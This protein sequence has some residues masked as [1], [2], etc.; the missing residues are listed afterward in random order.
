MGS[1]SA[2]EP[3][4]PPHVDISG[5][6]DA[7]R[8]EAEDMTG[9][10]GGER[11]GMEGA[12]AVPVPVATDEELEAAVDAAISDAQAVSESLE[13]V[14]DEVMRDTEDDEKAGD[15]EA[16][17]AFCAHEKVGNS[18]R[19]KEE[20]G[21]GEE[22]E[23]DTEDTIVDVDNEDN[24]TIPPNAGQKKEKQKNIKKN[25]TIDDARESTIDLHDECND[26]SPSGEFLPTT[27]TSGGTDVNSIPPKSRVVTMY[28]SSVQRAAF[29]ERVLQKRHLSSVSEELQSRKDHMAELKEQVTQATEFVSGLE[30]ELKAL[31]AEE[32]EIMSKPVIAKDKLS[33]LATARDKVT[34]NLEHQRHVVTSC[35]QELQEARLALRF[36]EVDAAEAD[37]RMKAILKLDALDVAKQQQLAQTLRHR[38]QAAVKRVEISLQESQAAVKKVEQQAIENERQI[39]RNARE[40]RKTALARLTEHQRSIARSIAEIQLGRVQ[41]KAK[42]VEALMKLKDSINEARET[43]VEQNKS[44]EEKDQ[45][46]KAAQKKE[47]AEL[48]AQGQNPYEV[49]RRRSVNAR[50]VR[51]AAM[52]DIKL[53]NQSVELQKKLEREEKIYQSEKAARAIEKAYEERFEREMGLDAAEER[54]RLYI[55]SITKDGRDMLDPT[56]RMPVQPREVTQ[57]KTWKFGMSMEPPDKEL[58]S[59]IEQTHSRNKKRDEAYLTKFSA[60]DGAGGPLTLD[61]RTR[62]TTAPVEI[63]LEMNMN[64][65]GEDGPEDDEVAVLL[66]GNHRLG[67]RAAFEAP[68]KTM[69]DFNEEARRRAHDKIL[70]RVPGAEGGGDAG[71]IV[72]KPPKVVFK[73]VQVGKRYRT[74]VNVTNISYKLNTFKLLELPPEL[75]D[76]FTVEYSVDKSLSAGMACAL[77]VTFEPKK[78]QDI[79][80]SISFLAY[81]GY[82]SLPVEC[83]QRR[84]DIAFSTDNVDFGDVPVSESR[85]YKLVITNSGALP[86]KFTATTCAMERM[87][88]DDDAGNGAGAHGDDHDDVFCV[89]K[90]GKVKGNAKTTLDIVFSPSAEVDYAQEVKVDIEAVGKRTIRLRGRG[91]KPAVVVRDPVIDFQYCVF[92]GTYRH[93]V[94]LSNRGKVALKMKVVPRLEVDKYLDVSPNSAFI[95]GG[96][97]FTFNVQFSPTAE[98]LSHGAR[99]LESGGDEKTRAGDEGFLNVPIKVN[100]PGQSPVTFNVRAYLTTGA[101]EIEP[102]TLSF[103]SVNVG[104]K[105]G[106]KVSL[107]NRSDL[108]QSFGFTCAKSEV[109]MD[110]FGLLLPHETITRTVTYTA[111]LPSGKS[112]SAAAG[113]ATSLADGGGLVTPAYG[114]GTGSG[115][116]GLHEFE[117]VCRS[118]FGHTYAIPCS[119]THVVTPLVL[120]SSLVR[121]PSTAT[122]DTRYASV[123]VRNV[124]GT[125]QTFEFRAPPN[126]GI[127]IN[128]SVDTV[129]TG[130]HVRVEVEYTPLRMSKNGKDALRNVF[131]DSADE[132]DGEEEEE[133]ASAAVEGG[134][135]SSGSSPSNGVAMARQDEGADAS[136]PSPVGSGTG[137]ARG[138]DIEDGFDAKHPGTTKWIAPCYIK[139]PNDTILHLCIETCDIEREIQVRGVE[140]PQPG[141]SYGTVD[142]GK[143]STSEATVKVLDVINRCDRPIQLQASTLRFENYFTIVN[144]LPLLA[145]GETRKLHV[146]FTPTGGAQA[147]SEMLTLSTGKQNVAINLVGVGAGRTLSIEPSDATVDMGDVVVNSRITKEFKVT[148]TS[149]TGLEYKLAMKGTCPQRHNGRASIYCSHVG[150]FLESGE[151]TTVGI[152]FAPDRPCIPYEDEV[153][154]MIE[155]NDG[156]VLCQNVR[157][158]GRCWG[159]QMYI[160]GAYENSQSSRRSTAELLCGIEGVFTT[161]LPRVINICF[162]DDVACGGSASERFEIGLAA[163]EGSK[164]VGEFHIE[165]LSAYDQQ[166]GWSVDVLQGSVNA[167]GLKAVNL[168]FNPPIE[169]EPDQLAFFGIAEWRH[170]SLKLTLKS[171][172][173]PP[174]VYM[175]EAKCHLVP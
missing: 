66:R 55:A 122:G 38:E 71:G 112:G 33:I 153:D 106:Q 73:D 93:A 116:G 32:D 156:L 12:D 84:A 133:E 35:E 39:V 173:S 162:A 21:E 140:L 107:T 94:T 53:R 83:Y 47:A 123:Y 18:G 141:R 54:T 151:S 111:P 42:R 144:Q 68:S 4:D 168:S 75:K 164:D 26:D 34:R 88:Y 13:R 81:T 86:A 104:E 132:H 80:S 87:I 31:K 115:G 82:S 23:E 8:D 78:A 77:H 15:E 146:K 174:S 61:T 166:C 51:E 163:C 41:T 128:P 160:Q 2:A 46:R 89:A 70:T 72:F 10:G 25:S 97:T 58:I 29:L 69:N 149:E 100:V 150:G 157:L 102:K 136:S 172:S 48:L 14:G 170:V 85:S 6:D 45:R 91:G 101:I 135:G 113:M 17:T 3:L 96:S 117:L 126:S 175:I 131:V 76:V 11:D 5:G 16:N 36:L 161:E 37:E 59:R 118:V 9:C 143:V 167:D 60:G 138:D 92:G 56:S 105:V 137:E 30:E 148:N 62:K 155:N 171:S 50:H 64:L 134:G 120:S 103:G 40:A 28:R 152:I 139:G 67:G 27:A 142:F 65:L 99:F 98:L 1:G 95:Q 44:R 110:S 159:G 125:S 22:E 114:H 108:P 127:V 63:G 145:P 57:L 119:A 165:S 19:L 24:N 129:K 52:H 124:S 109:H 49:F 74:K 20:E 130:R 90:Y 169:P 147:Y 154:F 43:I 79:N 7:A 121:M 158:T